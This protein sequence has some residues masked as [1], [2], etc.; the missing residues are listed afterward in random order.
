MT[1]AN[2]VRYHDGAAVLDLPAQIDHSAEPALKQAYTVAADHGATTLVLNFSGVEFLSSTGIAL[3][4]GIL[5]RARKERRTIR[6]T[7]L[8]DHYREIFEITRLADFM[9]IY[10]DENA[11]LEGG[12]R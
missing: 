11:A 4:V 2:A 9:T 5:A 7:G 12:E 6:A 8:S 10:A 1:M 3:I